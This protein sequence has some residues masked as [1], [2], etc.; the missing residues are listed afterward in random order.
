MQ[1]AGQKKRLLNVFTI[2]RDNNE[3][4]FG[5]AIMNTLS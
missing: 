1:L 2:S 5:G 3:F 4:N